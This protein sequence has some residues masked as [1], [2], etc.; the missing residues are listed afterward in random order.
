ML[1][2]RS[3]PRTDHPSLLMLGHTLFFINVEE[4]SP[5]ALQAL[6]YVSTAQHPVAFSID[7]LVLQIVV[8]AKQKTTVNNKTQQY[9]I[10][11][12]TQQ[13]IS[14]YFFCNLSEL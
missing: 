10:N 8:P 9:T 13:R 1:K 7:R 11:S 12:I 5:A 14:F 4:K 6:M 3:D 2:H